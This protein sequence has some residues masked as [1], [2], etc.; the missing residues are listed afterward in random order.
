MPPGIGEGDALAR[1]KRS[2]PYA[3]QLHLLSH[4]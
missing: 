2:E 4:C 1:L 3:G